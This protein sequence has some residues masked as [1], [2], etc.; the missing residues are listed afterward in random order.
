MPKYKVWIDNQ[1][2]WDPSNI[3]DGTE[4]TSMSVEAAAE[5]YSNEGYGDGPFDVIVLA[6]GDIYHKI[7]LQ[8]GWN[9]CKHVITTLEELCAP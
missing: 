6:P 1:E 5:Q 7:E 3:A 4:V 2:Q 9:V 8:R